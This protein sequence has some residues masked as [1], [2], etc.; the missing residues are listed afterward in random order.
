MA[1]AIDGEQHRRLPVAQPV[2][3][4]FAGHEQNRVQQLGVGSS[5]PVGQHGVA[6]QPAC[7][8]HRLRDRC[9]AARAAGTACR[10]WPGSLRTGAGAQPGEQHGHVV[11][12][13][14][15]GLHQRVGHR[16]EIGVRVVEQLARPAG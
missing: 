8:R 15:P 13:M 1:F 10:G 16:L 2:R 6:H 14:D 11:V 9:R 5:P 12:A 4:E 3:D 7:R